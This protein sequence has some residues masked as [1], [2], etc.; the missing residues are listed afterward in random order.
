M[1]DFLAKPTWDGAGAAYVLGLDGDLKDGRLGYRL[2]V[3][4]DGGVTLNGTPWQMIV[5]Q[6]R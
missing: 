2:E 5:P 4:Q 6:G 3:G 1:I